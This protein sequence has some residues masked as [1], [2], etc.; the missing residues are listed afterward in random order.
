MDPNKIYRTDIERMIKQNHPDF[1]AL[2]IHWVVMEFL[3]I[4]TKSVLQDKEV[5]IY[6]FGR[7]W[8]YKRSKGWKKH[9][10]SG[11][12][13]KLHTKMKFKI[14]QS[15]QNKIDRICKPTTTK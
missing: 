5:V 11:K 9:P 3:D 7:F 8:K 1:D 15:M 14:S 2:R 12:K 6:G 10:F 4:I 13:A